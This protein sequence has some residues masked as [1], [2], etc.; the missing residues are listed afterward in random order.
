MSIADQLPKQV[1][2]LGSQARLR[3]GGRTLVS[4]DLKSGNR[5]ALT[6]A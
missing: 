6:G 2:K 5:I 4:K 1:P 3:G